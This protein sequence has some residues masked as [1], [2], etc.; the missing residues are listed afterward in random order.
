MSPISRFH[1]HLKGQGKGYCPDI[2][3]TLLLFGTRTCPLYPH[4]AY[5]KIEFLGD[6]PDFKE[7]HV[8]FQTEDTYMDEL[9]LRILI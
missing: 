8:I 4:T 1:S 6:Y 3:Y 2:C 5:D 7:N 9:L